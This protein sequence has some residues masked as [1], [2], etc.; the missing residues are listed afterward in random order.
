M[1]PERQAFLKAIEENPY[2]FT[3]RLIFADWLEEFGEDKDYEEAVWQREWTPEWQ[4]SKEWLENYA[5]ELS[6]RDTPGEYDFSITLEELIETATNHLND[7]VGGTIY[8]PYDTPDMVYE[9]HDEFWKQYAVYTKK[10]L[11]NINPGTF[12]RCAC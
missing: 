7:F 1:N 10:N 12:I 2:D 5:D 4:R 3:T 8:L 6:R 9:N 11:D